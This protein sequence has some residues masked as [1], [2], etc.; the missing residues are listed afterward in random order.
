[1]RLLL[2]DLHAELDS[3]IAGCLDELIESRV[4]TGEQLKQIVG[5]AQ[6]A[7]IRIDGPAQQSHAVRAK[8]TNV[9]VV[10]A[11]DSGEQYRGRR[12]AIRE[13]VDRPVHPAELE[14]P[15]QHVLAEEP[16]R[17]CGDGG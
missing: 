12:L 1:M 14:E 10:T 11:V 13:A 16:A 15:P 8:L 3:A 9:E 6:L 2:I 4:R 7:F 17:N 5:E